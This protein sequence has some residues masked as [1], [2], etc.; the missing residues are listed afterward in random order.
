VPAAIEQRI[1]D[2]ESRK[3]DGGGDVASRQDL[4]QLAEQVSETRKRL[5]QV[6]SLKAEVASLAT[7]LE[8]VRSGVSAPAASGNGTTATAASGS[9][10]ADAAA[11]RGRLAKLES[12]LSALSSATD[13][14]GQPA[15]IAP[16]AKISAQFADLESSLNTQIGELRKSLLEQ[17]DGRVAGSNEASAKAVASS[18]RLDREFSEIKTDTA[19]L[20]QSSKV[21]KAASDKLA[22]TVRA[23]SDQAAS[24]KVELDGLKGDLKQELAKVARP[25]DV[26]EAIAPVSQKVAAIEK[27]LGSVLASESARKKNAERIVLSLELSNL[28]RVLDRGASYEAELAEVRKI[29]GDAIDFSSLDAHKSRGVPSGPELTRQFR[30]VAYAII[31]SEEASATD[32]VMDRLFAGAKSMVRVRRTDVP[33]KEKTAEAAVAR[34]EKQLKDGNMSGALALAEKLP[35]KAKAPAKEWM[36][37]LAARAGVD[38]AIEEIEG[39]LKASLGGGSADTG[40][41]S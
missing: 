9:G 31:N 33:E 7:D 36:S 23:V 8:K 16:L 2:L 17:I 24:L 18:E 35:D 21:I 28:K 32:S 11:V 25:S 12:A 13:G 22:T 38:R 3:S 20:E 19:R 4:T 30:D 14:K 15:G 26:N 40:K 41:K 39:Q 27:D 5:A 6:E 29:A 37:K 10:D 1:V 34:I